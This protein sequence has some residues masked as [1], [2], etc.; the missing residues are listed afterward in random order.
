MTVYAELSLNEFGRR[1]HLCAFFR[2]DEI[3]LFRQGKYLGEDYDHRRDD[4]DKCPAYHI[5][6]V[7]PPERSMTEYV[8]GY[9]G[10]AGSIGGLE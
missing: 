3:L 9:L 7:E 4:S 5:Q 8:M 6:A 1:L 2:V 10:L